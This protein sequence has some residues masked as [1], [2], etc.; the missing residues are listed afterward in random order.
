MNGGGGHHK[1]RGDADK[2]GNETFDQE[3]PAPACPA[4]DASH[5]KE[6][7]GKNGGDDSGGRQSGPEVAVNDS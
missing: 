3:E 2:E 7:K 1:E 6:S 5:V 4:R